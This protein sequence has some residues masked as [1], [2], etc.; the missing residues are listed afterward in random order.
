MKAILEFEAPVS[1]AECKLRYEIYNKNY[2]ENPQR[3]AA[4]QQYIRTDERAERAKFCPLRIVEGG[5]DA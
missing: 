2:L 5:E 3:C 4:A 1:C